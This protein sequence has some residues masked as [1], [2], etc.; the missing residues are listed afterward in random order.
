[1]DE[2]FEDADVIFRGEIE[3]RAEELVNQIVTRDRGLI[4]LGLRPRPTLGTTAVPRFDLLELDRYCSMSVQSSRGCPYHCEFCDVIEL[5]GRVPRVK[6]PEQ[7]LAELDALHALGWRGTVF[8]VDDNFIGN[9]REVRRLL[10]RLRAWQDERGRPFDLYT[11]ASVNLALDP[12]LIEEVVEAGFSAVFL[13]IETPSLDALRAAGKS[14]NLRLDLRDAVATL[15][16]AGL[17]VMGGFIVGFDSDGPEIFAAQ[18]QF[19]G[20][21]PIPM[22]MIGVLTALPGTALW[23]RLSREGRLRPGTAGDSTGDP[24]GRPN[25]APAL[26][27]EVLIR[28][29]AALLARLYSM[30]GYLAR[31]LA[32]L[33]LAPTPPARPRRRGGFAAFARAVWRLGVLAP[34][35]RGFWALCGAAVRR[36]PRHLTWAV[37]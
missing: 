28:E 21:A 8:F 36:H 9:V 24:F 14:Q 18:Q 25:F 10:P 35:R 22:A 33:R 12:A 34:E 29:Y 7:V 31:C 6:S 4:S 3:G 5:F 37:T 27:E 20:D 26:D 11:E 19:L 30:D 2:A 1:M 16:R 13:G 17:E 32:Y 23:T 15:T